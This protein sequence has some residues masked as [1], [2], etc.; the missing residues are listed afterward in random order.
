MCLLGSLWLAPQERSHESA[1][2]PRVANRGGC[3]RPVNLPHRKETLCR[4]RKEKASR[5]TAISLD[6]HSPILTD[7]IRVF[8]KMALVSTVILGWSSVQRAGLMD[9]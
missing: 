1:G 2:P 5:T 7:F 6:I 4:K 8:L 3:A 9:G